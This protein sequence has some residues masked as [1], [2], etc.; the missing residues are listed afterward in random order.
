MSFKDIV[1]QDIRS[2]FLNTEEF[3]ELHTVRY[4]GK[5]YADIPLS[6]QKIKQS[7]KTVVSGN[8]S[9]GIYLVSA[10]AYF[11]LKDVGEN[12]P[13]QGMIFAVDD[14]EAA[15]KPFFVKYRIVTAENSMGMACLELEAY[16]E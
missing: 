2:I 12:L 5:E 8:H 1:E 9:E 14:G 4:D 6:L 15:G 16:D 13:E 3:A 7:D 10:K 11:D